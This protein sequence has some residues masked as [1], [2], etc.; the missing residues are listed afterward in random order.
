M[1]A[2]GSPAAAAAEVEDGLVSATPVP[3][4]VALHVWGV[5]SVPKALQR[6]AFD[7]RVVR[8]LPGCTFAKLLGTGSGSTFTLRDTDLHHW[9][10]L[11][12]WDDEDGPA[13]FATSRVHGSWSADAHES[14][15]LLLR[16]LRSR[17][18]WSA[19]APFGDPHAADAE[20]PVAALTRARIR[21]TQWAR[22][23]RSVPPVA[24]DSH[25]GGGLQLALGIGEA[26]IGLQGT[27]TVWRDRDALHDFTYRRSPHA[28]AIRRTTKTGWYAEELFARFAVV[29]TTGTVGGRT[30][31]AELT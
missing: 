4:V 6:M 17:G 29:A 2:A 25:A 28:D 15:R 7:R 9:A 19:V 26:P 22:F 14:A 21:P 24:L 3:A 11:T 20:G 27:F 5:R 13:R 18:R 1:R 30:P 10:V 31:A 16:P 12:C 8:S 23:W